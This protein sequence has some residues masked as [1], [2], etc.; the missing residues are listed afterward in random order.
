MVTELHNLSVV[1]FVGESEADSFLAAFNCS[2]LI[3]HKFLENEIGVT[4]MSYQK[5]FMCN[6]GKSTKKLS[7]FVL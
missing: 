6:E 1:L 2:V 3:N 5:S 4:L 7:M